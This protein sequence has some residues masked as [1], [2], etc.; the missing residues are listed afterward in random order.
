MNLTV[1]LE[2]GIIISIII[3]SYA[4]LLVCIVLLLEI[5]MDTEMLDNT[6]TAT[7]A[8]DTADTYGLVKSELTLARR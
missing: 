8:Y 7:T 2:G 6:T 5:H 4:D 1:Y 3:G